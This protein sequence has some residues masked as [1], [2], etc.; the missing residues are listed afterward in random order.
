MFEQLLPMFIVFGGSC[1]YLFLWNESLKRRQILKEEVLRIINN[2]SYSPTLKRKLANSFLYSGRHFFILTL[3]YNVFKRYFMKSFVSNTRDNINTKKETIQKS[4]KAIDS[5][6]FLES[7]MVNFI[8]SP[9]QLLLMM[10]VYSIIRAHDFIF[11]T[12]SKR[13]SDSLLDTLMNQIDGKI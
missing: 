6:I 11:S 13:I 1:A 3:L 9:L 7:M 12:D 4:E 5:R 8:L 2:D 10:I